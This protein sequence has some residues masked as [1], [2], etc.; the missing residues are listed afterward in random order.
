[1]DT[2][3]KYTARFHHAC[4]ESDTIATPVGAMPPSHHRLRIG[5]AQ[6]LGQI[7]IAHKDG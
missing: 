5:Q 2:D 4:Y 6:I 1:M 3:I 7:N